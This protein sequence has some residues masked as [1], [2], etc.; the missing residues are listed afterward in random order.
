MR[1][2]KLNIIF[3]NPV[4]TYHAGEIVK[5]RVVVVLDSLK[6]YRGLY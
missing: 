5:G 4:K 3:D 2:K 1:L 6:K